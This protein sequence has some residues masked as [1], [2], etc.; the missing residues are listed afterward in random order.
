MKESDNGKKEEEVEF[1]IHPMSLPKD[2]ELK[3]IPI[4][5]LES[6]IMPEKAVEFKEGIVCYLDIMGFSKKQTNEDLEMT[7]ADFAGALVQPAEEFKHIRFHIFSDC[8]FLATSI[9]PA[10]DLLSAVRYSFTQWISD[11]ILVRGGLAIG[12][13][14][15]NRSEVQDLAPKNF[16]WSF[17]A[18]SGVVEAV[19]L[20]GSGKGALLYSS[21]RCSKYFG[22]KFGEPIFVLEN[23]KIIG[24]TKEFRYLYWY[25]GNS[26]LR[27]LKILSTDKGEIHSA[28]QHYL[29]NIKYALTVGNKDLVW[30]LILSLLSIPKLNG[31]ARKKAMGLLNIKS[32]DIFISYKPEI[33]LFLADDLKIKALIFFADSDSGVPGA[34]FI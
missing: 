22:E 20:E 13:Y 5:E 11:S 4:S 27:L 29:T 14:K 31:N 23:Q 19:K 6:A 15:E 30:A 7:L 16:S 1:P 24:W 12:S 21:D 8:A 10:E 28:V 9:D 17:F 34:L 3:F 25:I 2:V 33:E 18:G 32:E 26:L